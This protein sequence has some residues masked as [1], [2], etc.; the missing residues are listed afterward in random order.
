LVSTGVRCACAVGQPSGAL[1]ILFGNWPGEKDFSDVEICRGQFFF[2]D[3]V[4]V[5]PHFYQLL[6]KAACLTGM[7][8][9]NIGFAWNR[10]Y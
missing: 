2:E 8:E 4:K 1:I 3:P 5:A 7:T 10:V 6:L 9:N